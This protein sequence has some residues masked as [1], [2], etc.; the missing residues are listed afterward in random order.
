MTHQL[1]PNNSKLNKLVKYV[2]GAKPYRI[3]N[4]H[5]KPNVYKKG[6]KGLKEKKEHSHYDMHYDS[7]TV[8]TIIVLILFIYAYVSYIRSGSIV[9]ITFKSLLDYLT[10]VPN[11]TPSFYLVDFT[12]AGSWGNF[13]F[14]RDFLNIFASFFGVTFA[15]FGFLI[16]GFIFIFWCVRFFFI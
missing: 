4:P 15:V 3:K 13:N 14:L 11:L 10:T 8:F 5:L 1:T 2:I 9:T 12:I 7:K 16:Q 6:F